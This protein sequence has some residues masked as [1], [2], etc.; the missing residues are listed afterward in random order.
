MVDKDSPRVK[1]L[2]KKTAG[3]ARRRLTVIY[4]ICKTKT[5]CEGGDELHAIGGEVIVFSCF[6]IYIVLVTGWY[7]KK[8]RYLLRYYTIKGVPKYVNN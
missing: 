5:V 3:N 7:K 4:E 2:L 8:K 6:F 1:E